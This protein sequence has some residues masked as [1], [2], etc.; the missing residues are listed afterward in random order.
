M[1]A[2]GEAGRRKGVEVGDSNALKSAGKI[3]I[4]KAPLRYYLLGS[5]EV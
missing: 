2:E 1:R 4:N 5:D 3:K